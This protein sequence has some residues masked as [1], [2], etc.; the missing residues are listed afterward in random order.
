MINV[1]IS[2]AEN[3]IYTFRGDFVLVSVL[4]SIILNTRIFHSAALLSQF[5]LTE[6]N[7]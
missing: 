7:Q 2:A 1:N 6:D 3:I 4:S 5:L